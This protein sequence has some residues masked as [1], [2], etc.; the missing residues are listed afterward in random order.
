M[1]GN[2]DNC[3]ID[4]AKVKDRVLFQGHQSAGAQANALQFLRFR[5][6]KVLVMQFEVRR[7]HQ[8]FLKIDIAVNMVKMAMGVHY[9]HGQIGQS[10]DDL[11]EVFPSIRRVDQQRL[12]VSHDE[13]TGG[14]TRV[15]DQDN[16]FV[17][18]DDIR[19]CSHSLPPHN[20][21]SQVFCC[22]DT[23]LLPTLCQTK[24]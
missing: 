12:L 3:Q 23:G 8:S 6:P 2:R 14:V 11:P 18:V 21:F 20:M 17:D 9:G 15:V 7:M 10:P 24:R 22:H 4:A 5:E 16:V 1:S 19:S 13:I